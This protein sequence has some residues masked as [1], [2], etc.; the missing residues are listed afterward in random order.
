MRITILIL[1]YFLLS[2]SLIS[3][4]PIYTNEEIVD[5]IYLAEGGLK[6]NYPFGIKSVNCQGYD[7]CRQVC[8]N[9]VERNK[10]RYAQY[11]YKQYKD[12]LNFL[13]SR[14][15]PLSV[16]GCDTWVPNVKFFLNKEKIK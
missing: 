12:F 13:G 11:G 14:Y 4:E 2:I 15:C 9:T 16:E 5:A 10:V 6:T 8:V 7:E 3:A 1:I